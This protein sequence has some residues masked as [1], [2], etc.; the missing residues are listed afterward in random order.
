MS[1]LVLERR[2]TGWDLLLGALLA[3]A[4]FIVLGHTVLATVVSVLFIGW[5]TL[6]SGLIALL[7]ALFRIGR[8]GFWSTALSGGLLTVLGLMFVRN[9]A[10]AALTLTLIAGSLFLV[11]GVTRLVA[12]FQNDAYRWALLFGGVVST[13]LGLSVLFNVLEATLTLL[14]VLL[15]VQMLVDGITLLLIGRIHATEVPAADS[16]RR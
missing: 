9:P 10:V 1:N 11:S 3:I 2:Q 6:V 16:V 15:G 13:V 5:L 12:A 8:G 14:G 4:G 7:A